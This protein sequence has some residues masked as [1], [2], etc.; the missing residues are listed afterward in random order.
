M[1]ERCSKREGSPSSLVRFLLSEARRYLRA[2][3]Q[4]VAPSKREESETGGSSSSLVRP[5]L[6]EA[7]RHFRAFGQGVAPSKQEEFETEVEYAPDNPRY[8][9]PLRTGEVPK[10]RGLLGAAP[11]R[12]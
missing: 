5:L 6:S 2:F 10:V 1:S 8:L 7:R 12:D 9:P 3:G 11:N 4:G